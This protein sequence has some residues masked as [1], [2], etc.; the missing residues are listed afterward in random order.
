MTIQNPHLLPKVRS[1]AIMKAARG[2]PCSLRISSFLG[3][4]CS[5][6]D[7]TVACHLPVPGKGTKTKVS[8]LFVAFGCS[9]CHAILDGNKGVELRHRYPAAYTERLWFGMAETQARLV[10]MG[11]IV[12]P[13]GEII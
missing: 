10:G 12:V 5:D 8:D 4:G 6:V 7:T 13:D 11:L 3:S 2:Q 9:N 1:E